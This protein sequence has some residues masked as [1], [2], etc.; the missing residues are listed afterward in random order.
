MCLFAKLGVFMEIDFFLNFFK[1]H[2]QNK[3]KYILPTQF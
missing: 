1:I 3:N 2:F